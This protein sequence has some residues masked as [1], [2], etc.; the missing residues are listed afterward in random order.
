[1][2]INKTN[3]N[4]NI[5]IDV[6]G[7]M[8]NLLNKVSEIIE[9]SGEIPLKK[10]IELRD[11][12]VSL[13]TV[14]KTTQINVSPEV[15][16]KVKKSL[17][18]IDDSKE[19]NDK[20]I[21]D[22]N[23][24]K[25]ESDKF[26]SQVSSSTAKDQKSLSVVGSVSSKNEKTNN[27]VLITD[28]EK[29]KINAEINSSVEHNIKALNDIINSTIDKNKPEK[30]ID[31]ENIKV[32][33]VQSE[34]LIRLLRI[35]AKNLVGIQTSIEKEFKKEIDFLRTNHSEKEQKDVSFDPT[36]KGKIEKSESFK[37][38]SIPS[39]FKKNNSEI[40][41]E[42]IKTK[43]LQES[44][45]SSIEKT[46]KSNERVNTTDL[47]SVDKIED[48]ILTD[49][50][51]S[52]KEEDS[53]GNVK[54]TI[55]DIKEIGSTAKRLKDLK[56]VS[57]ITNK[58]DKNTRNI[59]QLP[60]VDDKKID[61]DITQLTIEDD[62]KIDQNITQLIIE[63]DKK[64]I[65]DITQ[66]PIVDDKKIDQ[67]ITQLPIVDDNK[68]NQNITQLT[69]E[70][71]K[72]N[73]NEIGLI[74]GY[75]I[76]ITSKENENLDST[77]HS[78]KTGLSPVG[79]GYF[80]T[81][82]IDSEE[83]RSAKSEENLSSTSHSPKT[84][85]IQ[86]T[87]NVGNLM[88]NE[89]V[90]INVENDINQLSITNDKNENDI[91][92][93]P[94][95]EDI[96]EKIRRRRSKRWS[97]MNNDL[98]TA[99][100]VTKKTNRSITQL[101]VPD[102]SKTDANVAT[103]GK[104]SSKLEKTITQLSIPDDVNEKMRKVSRKGVA[105]SMNNDIDYTDAVEDVK[106]DYTSRQPI[107]KK[108][109]SQKLD[110]NGNPMFKENTISTIVTP[111]DIDGK[112]R[113]TNKKGVGLSMENDI[114]Y[115]DA[116]EDS[117]G[118]ITSSQP[119]LKEDGSQKLDNDG[120][121]IFKDNTIDYTDASEDVKGDII[122]SQPVLKKN[123]SQKLDSDGNPIFKDNTITQNRNDGKYAD[124]VAA[125]MFD[126]LL[127]KFYPQGPQSQNNIGQSPLG[128]WGS[129]WTNIN[130]D[131]GSLLSFFNLMSVDINRSIVKALRWANETWQS[132][133]LSYSMTAAQ[134][135]NRRQKE[136]GMSG[137]SPTINV[138][139]SHTAPTT[140]TDTL[141]GSV[142]GAGYIKVYFR[143]GPNFGGGS[144]S[145]II[146]IP[147]QFEPDISG[148]GKGAEYS[149]STSLGRS[150]ETSIYKSSS[151]RNVN[152][153]LTYVVTGGATKGQAYDCVNDGMDSWT[154]DYIYNYVLRWYKLLV[155]PNVQTVAGSTQTKRLAPP[156]VQVWY[157]G[158]GDST[159]SS[160]GVG[161]TDADNAKGGTIH[162]MFRTN[163][164]TYDGSSSSAKTYR[165]LWVAKSVNFEYKEGIV[166]KASKNKLSVVV[167]LSLS[168]I[169]P[170]MTDNEI[171][172]YRSF[173]G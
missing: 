35:S 41:I 161:D 163:W 100:T 23:K 9:Y 43:K 147:F 164:Y 118:E 142:K 21:V 40:D 51:K 116:V 59:T 25:K 110:N 2:A 109:G 98:D 27:Q 28:D 89:G 166:N 170:S 73:T 47:S 134:Y 24:T 31:T 45:D 103:K 48:D 49:I 54:P 56:N 150:Q 141:T 3:K 75:D 94:I 130:K 144:S 6:N 17:V 22:I 111:D 78:P 20:I 63:D 146:I 148:D 44:I 172:I 76:E 4:E 64:I 149:S 36:I 80:E 96:D 39:P 121:P 124:P 1:M 97:S 70:D 90:P 57:R 81:N 65:N 5:A 158:L 68:I 38:G 91:G 119:I 83:I 10:V 167:S 12:F 168:E 138:P 61:Q 7:A 136:S 165:S 145:E 71:D 106:G 92:E 123:G 153:S 139:T 112:M 30:A 85:V 127:N 105:S 13:Q 53:V 33:K 101:T 125:N 62:K 18:V 173:S 50:K 171:G 60:I 55:K 8:N 42:K 32:E 120:N 82:D 16:D 52:I 95:S 132:A 157:G 122:S 15:I 86:A 34:V 66:L 152:L 37:V 151:A 29:Q 99:S 69:I 104:E 88:F 131:I 114:D 108:D 87:D 129:D 159:A 135:A 143:R 19:K 156:I 74:K 107:L 154:E 72:K 155:L 162:P 26:S 160:L 133:L 113:K 67:N 128:N 84:G 115:I 77:S 14:D 169:P 46:E 93:L 58:P 11:A 126:Q 117:K 140:R 79:G 102:D 137:L